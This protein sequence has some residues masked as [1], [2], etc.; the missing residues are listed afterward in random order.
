MRPLW[1]SVHLYYA[2][3]YYSFLEKG[4]SP[5]VE[6]LIGERLISSYFFVHYFDNGLHVRLRL[7]KSEAV[8]ERKIIEGIDKFYTT[9]FQ[10]KAGS[11]RIKY[12]AY[13]PE[14]SRYGGPDFLALCESQFFSSSKYV[15]SSIINSKSWNYNVAITNAIT[16]HYSLTTIL[17]FDLKE[18]EEFF[19]L[20]F[21]SWIKKSKDYYEKK[22][23]EILND[24]EILNLFKKSFHAQ[25]EKILKLLLSINQAIID[26]NSYGTLQSW[27]LDIKNF[28][29]KANLTTIETN[30][31]YH[32]GISK[33]YRPWFIY[34]SLVHMS[35]NRLGIQN[36][37]E[38]FIAFMIK[39]LL[40]SMHD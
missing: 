11:K 29:D 36:K 20:N 37:D 25:E 21:Q 12:E 17:G 6:K 8:P 15:L 23:N 1:I 3:P 4:I 30:S 28:S 14:V 22:N 7:K 5:F 10:I 26:E 9:Y 35:N 34:D 27:K 40:P 38:A 39:S 13:V 31:D 18:K 33:R 24:S 19:E 32:S 16:L 2:E